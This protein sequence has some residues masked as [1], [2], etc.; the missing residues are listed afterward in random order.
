MHKPP[1]TA[2]VMITG[3]KEGFSY[4]SALKKA[5][6]SISLDKLNIEKTKIRRAANGNM[7]I[8]VIGHNG[9][10]KAIALKEKLS[11]VLKD[12]ARITRSVVKGDLRLVGL[13][14]STS[15]KDVIKAICS[16]G[17]CVK[18]DI[19]V[20]DIRT[21]NNRL[22]TSWVQ[23]PLG[24]A[25]KIANLGKIGI[26]W[27]LARVDLLATRPTQCFKCWRFGHFRNACKSGDDF[28]GLCFKCGDS[29]H[30]AK[31]CSA[32]PACKICLIDGKTS[33]DRRERNVRAC[34]RRL[35]R[36]AQLGGLRIWRYANMEVK[37]I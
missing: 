8:E 36:P 3:L 37:F 4:A 20:G 34:L 22:C 9:A 23:C 18:E 7:L 33:F 11:K 13:D 29:G 14:V 24:A 21:L 17:N 10:G 5:R 35:G 16:Y 26:G 32:P 6:E 2:A 27:T 30:A 12:E 31:Q 1:R 15:S 19:K 28:S 25:V